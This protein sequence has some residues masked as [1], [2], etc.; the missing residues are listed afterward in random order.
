[1]MKSIFYKPVKITHQPE[2]VL[3]WSD[4]HYGHDPA[5]DVPLWKTRGY[6]SC[7]EHDRGLIEKWNKKATND[8]HVFLLGDV[9]FGKDAEKNLR[10]LFNVLNFHHMYIMFGNHHAGI[11]QVFE[12][13]PDNILQ[14]GEKT[15]MFCPN[16]LEVYINKQALVL[17]HYAIL[18]WNGQGAG[19]W[20]LF[21]HSHG[22]LPKSKL[23]RY[24]L[25]SGLKCMEVC[26][27][28]FE[29]PPNFKEIQ[30]LMD[31]KKGMAIDHHDSTIS[32]P[33]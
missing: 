30:K 3:V 20:H 27:E 2:D 28:D 19:S 13:I 16:Y 17:S 33:F 25:E 18:N 7:A 1:M 6:N 8:S 24:Y 32:S 14:I 15:V 10:Y 11:K 5:W 23:G 31:A 26:V 22:S 4:L 29:S 9:C 12:S 21:G